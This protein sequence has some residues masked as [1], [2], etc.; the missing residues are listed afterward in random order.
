M[1]GIRTIQPLHR[2]EPFSSWYLGLNGQVEDPDRLQWDGNL[3]VAAQSNTDVG[4]LNTE[5]Q[6]EF[7]FLPEILTNENHVHLG[8]GVHNR[9][10]VDQWFLPRWALNHYDMVRIY[11]EALESK[12]VQQNLGSW[13]DLVFGY[14]QFNPAKFNQ[15]Y[16]WMYP[17]WWRKEKMYE[18][19]QKR[20]TDDEIADEIGPKM[21]DFLPEEISLV[22]SLLHEGYQV[23]LK[24]FNEP[25]MQAEEKKQQVIPALEENHNHLAQDKDDD[26][27]NID[28]LI[29]HFVSNFENQNRSELKLGR[30]ADY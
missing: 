12:Y 3:I 26:K 10:N 13:I 19:W 18:D 7:F 30:C 8:V 15:F 25:I 5:L 24:L 2:L 1:G 28:N 14:D 27:L 29:N 20:R 21:P 9:K 11:R 23:P 4:A 22:Y 6:P 17:E 16:P